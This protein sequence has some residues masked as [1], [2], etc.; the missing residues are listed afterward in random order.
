MLR[1]A[2]LGLGSMGGPMAR[3]I[4]GAGFPVIVWNRDPRRAAPF[5]ALG[6]SVAETPRQAASRAEVVCTMLA[7]PLAVEAV[8]SGPDGLLAGLSPGALWLDFSTVTPA[9]SRACDARTRERGARFCDVPVAGS[10]KPA[11]DGTLKI[12]AGGDAADLERARPVLEAV[13][14]GVL[15]FGPVGQGSAMK[16][17]N[18][19]LFGVTLAAFGEALGLA[20]R[21]GLPEKETTEWLLSIPSVSPYLK[22]KMDFLAGGG[23]PPAFQLS[24]MEKDLRLMVEAGGGPFHAPVV[25][26]ARHDYE[27]ARKAGL[28]ERDFAHVLSFLKG[29]LPK[30]GEPII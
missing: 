10:V 29:P 6:V 25:D 30:S 22:A 20:R 17:V 8:A 4:V 24:L 21:L 15:N 12:L 27:R 28:G 11:A 18:N 3:R 7:D 9:T 2:F 5:S 1:V 19:L 16:L 13:S 14:K 26:A 23:D